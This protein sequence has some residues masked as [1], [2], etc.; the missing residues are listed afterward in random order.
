MKLVKSRE[1]P[2]IGDLVRSYANSTR[3]YRVVSVGQD[4]VMVETVGSLRN[5]EVQ[6]AKRSTILEMK[7]TPEKGRLNRGGATFWTVTPF[8]SRG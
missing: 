3:L 7:F 6:P 8:V 1:A 4:G 5:G 2:Q